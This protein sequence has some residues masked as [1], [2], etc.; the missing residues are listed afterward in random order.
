MEGLCGWTVKWAY[1]PYLEAL[2]AKRPM[3]RVT[4]GS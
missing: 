2:W 4:M 1:E 3:I